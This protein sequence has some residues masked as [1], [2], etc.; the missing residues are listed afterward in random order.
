MGC[1]L[2]VVI[3]FLLINYWGRVIDFIVIGVV[4]SIYIWVIV[5]EI[6]YFYW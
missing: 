5:E 2:G 1:K 6:F 4:V 3:F